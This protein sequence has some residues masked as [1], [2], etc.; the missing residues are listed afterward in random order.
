VFFNHGHRP[1]TRTPHVRLDT[2]KCKACWKC[3]K[4][5]PSQVI[6]KI[7][8]PGH[9]HA[10]IVQPDFCTGCLNCLDICKQGAYSI[11]DQAKQETEKKRTRILNNFVINNL[12]LVTGLIMIFSGMVLQIGFH[13]GGPHGHDFDAA[14]AQSQTTPYEQLRK[15]DTNKIVCGFNY[16]TWTDIHKFII[17]FFSLL[18]I[19]HT[20]VHWK[21]YKIVITRKL[22]TKNIQV[23][24]LSALFLAVA[25]TGLVPWFIDL[26]GGTSIF[27]LLFIEIHDKL[28]LI[29]I[30]FL[31]LH[32]VKK[33]KWF[34]ATYAKLNIAQSSN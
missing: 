12:L 5:C 1:H 17:V 25:V 27:R 23:I 21:W 19:Y 4:N 2:S 13:M 29:L 31:F 33:V 11:N 28:T 3:I 15:I 6:N 20:Y 30:V 16:Y 8:L 10:L 32:F 7:D 18:M 34:S 14:A 24:I 22:F 9:R 26:S